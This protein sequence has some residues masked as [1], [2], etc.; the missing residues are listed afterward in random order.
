MAMGRR[1]KYGDGE[2]KKV[3]EVFLFLACPRPYS[4]GPLWLPVNLDDFPDGEF[5]WQDWSRT[6]WT[7]PLHGVADEAM[8]LLLKKLPSV[9]LV[10]AEYDSD[11]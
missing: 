1:R 2:K 8:N 7:D 4:G 3:C 11:F 10:N 9:F 5:G 6:D